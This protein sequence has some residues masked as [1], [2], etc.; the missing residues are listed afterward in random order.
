MNHT[1][2]FA[3]SNALAKVIVYKSCDELSVLAQF[4][5]YRKNASRS[6]CY[7]SENQVFG[8]ATNRDMLLN[9]TCLYS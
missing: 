8:G 3:K 4:H 7:N 1:L 2:V 9:E 6:T 5:I